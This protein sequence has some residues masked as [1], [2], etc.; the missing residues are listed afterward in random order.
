MAFL[1]LGSSF[2]P[3]S[4]TPYPFSLSVNAVRL[5]IAIQGYLGPLM[6]PDGE[7]SIASEPAEAMDRLGAQAPN[8]WGVVLCWHGYDGPPDRDLDTW[9]DHAFSAFV[10]VPTGLPAVPGD[11]LIRQV[12]TPGTSVIQRIEWVSLAIRRIRFTADGADANDLDPRSPRLRHSGWVT[13]EDKKP[14]CIHELRFEYSAGLDMAAEAA[15]VTV[16]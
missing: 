14:L 8:K 11:A 9:M 4:L 1:V 10:R 5:L 6:A 7:L 13:K 16:A 12:T 15:V 2:R 3:F